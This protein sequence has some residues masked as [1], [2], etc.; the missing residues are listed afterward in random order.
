MLEAPILDFAY[1]VHTEIELN[2]VRSSQMV[3]EEEG[4]KCE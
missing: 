3:V 4:E 2:I 1:V